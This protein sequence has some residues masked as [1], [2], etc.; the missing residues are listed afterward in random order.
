VQTEEETEG[1]MA[2]S[3]LEMLG[4]VLEDTV[5]LNRAWLRGAAGTRLRSVTTEQQSASGALKAKVVSVALVAAA[6]FAVV[7]VRQARPGLRSS[8]QQPEV[9][10]VMLDSTQDL[11]RELV[12]ADSDKDDDFWVGERVHVRDAE[13]EPWKEGKVT[14][15]LPLSVTPSGWEDAFSWKIVR[16]GTVP[17]GAAVADKASSAAAEAAKRAGHAQAEVPAQKAREN[18]LAQ[19]LDG[20]LAEAKRLEQRLREEQEQREGGGRKHHASRAA[21]KKPT[22]STTLP[23][24]TTTTTKAPSCKLYGCSDNYQ[25]AN[26]CQCNLDCLPHGNCCPDFATKCQAEELARTTQT[27]TTTEVST[28][29]TL[30]PATSLPQIVTDPSQW[31]HPSLFCFSLVRRHGFEPDLVKAQFEQGVGIFS[32]DDYAVLSNSPITLG[33]D[34]SG[35]TISGLLVKAPHVTMGKWGVNGQTTNSWLNTL[36]FMNAWDALRTDGRVWKFDWTIK[37]DPDA[38]LIPDRIRP[39]L[40]PHTPKGG[41]CTFVLNCEPQPGNPL[42]YGAVEVFSKK[43]VGMYLDNEARCKKLD[44]DG[45]G[46]DYFMQQCLNMLGSNHTVKTDMVSDTNCHSVPCTD[47]SKA[48]YHPFKS[49]Q[50]WFDCWGQ[51]TALDELVR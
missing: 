35:R 46:E 24:T 38:V 40:Q 32:C 44:W 1:A 23:P 20:F 16:A 3:R 14:K 43:A 41:E 18:P 39:I 30:A 29:T 42:L 2:R 50:T 45:W 12:L 11:R 36:N 13:S 47:K 7:T 9:A 6:I 5:P 19:G 28:S 51:T 21:T 48:A 31:G 26:H 4:E 10:A 15:L 33:P 22:T 25:P 27:T 49:V 34:R 8:Q 17:D 37:V